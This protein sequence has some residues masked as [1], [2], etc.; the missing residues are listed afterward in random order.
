MKIKIPL[1]IRI[2]IAL[3]LGTLFGAIFSIDQNSLK[4][5]LLDNNIEKEFLLKDW[6]KIE[7]FTKDKKLDTI[8]PE[9]FFQNEQMKIIRFFNSLSESQRKEIV[10]KVYTEEI[11]EYSSITSI[12]RIA[13]IASVIKPIGDIFIRLLSFLAIPLVFASLLVGSASLDDLKKFGRIGLKTF[14]FYIITTIIA[15]SIGLIVANI[16]QPGTQLTEQSKTNLIDQYQNITIEKINKG[17]EIDIIR[18]FVEIVP[19]NPFKAIADG[20]MLQI[21]FFAVVFGLVL[22]FIDKRRAEPVIKFFSGMSEAMIKL[23]GFIMLFAPFGVF[24]LISS[25]VAEFGFDIITT[26][27]WYMFTVILG[28]FI[29]TL[30]VYPLIVR[31]FGKTNPIKFFKAMAP[32][33]A[34]AFSTS[35]SAATLPVT[36]DCVEN[37][38]GVPNYISSFVLP[39]GATINMDGTALYQGVAAVFIAQVYGIDLNLVQQITIVL[40]AVLASIGTAPVPGVGIIMLVMILQSVNIPPEGIAL[41]IGVDRFLDMCRTIPNITGDASVALAIYKTEKNNNY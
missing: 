33:Q 14:A 18:F 12:D 37:R 25:T 41:I 39:L 6:H 22:T 27:F 9:V 7:I 11:K 23:V 10:L 8:R 29:Q 32:A 21:I 40:T 5:T 31:I 13:T 26:L 36:F 15:I 1:Y 19:T 20:Q 3:I 17:Q 30:L 24:A 2:L 35:S 38:L 16:I 28:L 34:V 4:L